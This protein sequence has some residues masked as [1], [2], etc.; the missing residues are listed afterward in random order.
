MAKSLAEDNLDADVE[1]V[2]PSA[3]PVR[4]RRSA[5]R[6][7]ATT[8]RNRNKTRRKSKVAGGIHLRANKKIS[9]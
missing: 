1:T 7:S 6:A 4:L 5:K 8:T 3:R 2:S 9:W